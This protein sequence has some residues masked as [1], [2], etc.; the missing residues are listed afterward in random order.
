MA[1]F[2]V[3]TT[4]I[5]FLSKCHGMVGC[6]KGLSSGHSYDELGFCRCKLTGLEFWRRVGHERAYLTSGTPVSGA[7]D[8]SMCDACVSG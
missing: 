2:K 7:D 8:G 4:G 6:G 5:Y 1:N 3:T